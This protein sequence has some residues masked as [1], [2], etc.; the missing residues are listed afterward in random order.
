VDDSAFVPTG[1]TQ[2]EAVLAS[3]R[4]APGVWASIEG[5]FP[6]RIQEVVDGGSMVVASIRG[7]SFWASTTEFNMLTLGSNA[8]AVI[9]TDGEVEII[10]YIDVIDNGDNTFTLQRLLRGRLGT[11]DV[12]DGGVNVGDKVVGLKDSNGFKQDASINKQ[13]IPLSQLNTS[14]FFRGV[15]TGTLLE[16]ADSV[17]FTYTGRDIKPFSVAHMN[18]VA[19]GEAVHVSW[20]R[21]TRGPFGGEWLDGTGS[22]PLNEIIEQFEAS[23]TDGINTITRVVD[24]EYTLTFSPNELSTANIDINTPGSI[25]TVQQVSGASDLIKSPAIDKTLAAPLVAAINPTFSNVIL[26]TGFDLS[27]GNQTAFVEESSVGRTI[28]FVNQGQPDTDV[29]KFGRASYLGDG[30]ADACSVPQHADFDLGTDLFTIECWAKWIAG[31]D[32]GIFGRSSGGA[33]RYT[34]FMDANGNMEFYATASGLTLQG[35]SDFRTGSWM[36]LAVVRDA[37]NVFRLYVNGIREH[38]VT[39][40]RNIGASVDPFFIGT[41]PASF[42]ARSWNGWIDE[43]RF[44]RGEA[45]YSAATIV[46]PIGAFARS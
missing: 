45:L 12:A 13:D 22:V 18:A 7:V 25:V 10:N 17:S 2:T 5:D 33:D 39:V 30:V 46:P 34:L 29:K 3:V 44:T 16:D 23:I 36:H 21:R 11:E 40:A 35:T 27:D 41:D 26:L 32:K 8:I 9:G 19:S 4:T 42:S 24:D 20:D 31:T 1:T 37:G 14:L 38:Q 15:T 43:F 28:S 6:N